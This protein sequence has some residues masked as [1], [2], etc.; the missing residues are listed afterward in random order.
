[1]FWGCDHEEE[2]GVLSFL[3]SAFSESLSTEAE[4]QESHDTMAFTY[5]SNSAG[6]GNFAATTPRTR[7]LGDKVHLVSWHPL[8][9][10]A[11]SFA[12][13]QSAK[14]FVFEAR[15]D[16]TI[17]SV[18]RI[19]EELAESG[20]VSLTRNELSRMMGKLFIARTQVNLHSD[21]LDEPEFLWEYEDWEPSFHK[22][23]SYLDIDH[24]VELLNKRLD[25]IRELLD[26]LD[27]QLESKNSSRLEWIVIILI[28]IE[29]LFEVL[30][31]SI[32]LFWGGRL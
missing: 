1:V 29:I 32:G 20:S 22:L 17:N 11:V 3:S 9:K 4:L 13:A 28:I 30:W 26:V 15:L 18:K 21:I 16:V 14:L 23:C 5:N 10:L 2:L 19:P 24:R 31:D 12:L 8:E 25:L 27:T 7:V 6:P